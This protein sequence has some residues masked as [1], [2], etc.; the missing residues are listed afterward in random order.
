[1]TKKAKNKNDMGQVIVYKNKVE[2][3][4]ENE[5]V[6]LS[7]NQMADLFERDKSVLSRHLNNVFKEKELAKKSTVANFATVQ[8]EG[9]RQI[10]RRIEY[11]NL[12][13]IISVGYR[14]NSKRGTQFRI[15]ATNVLRK[16]LVEGYTLNK[17]RL[18]KD[19][20]KY[21]ELQ[22]AINLI[23]NVGLI[24]EL[25]TEAK[26][27]ISVISDYARALD[28]LDDYDHQCLKTPKGLKRAKPIFTYEKAKQIILTM[29]EKFKDSPLVGLEKDQ[30]FKSSVNAVYQTFGAKDVYPSVQ[31]K[32]AHLLYFVVK[33][34]SFV[35][36]NK[37]IAAALFIC[38]LD[39]YGILYRKDK[40]KII[41]DMALVGLT[42]MIASS[43]PNEKKMIIKVILNLLV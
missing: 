40:S 28:V 4:L 6:W 17:E 15:W 13:A 21:N 24:A 3:R 29:R 37:R 39:M 5:T 30:S 43:R 18:S 34:H 12:D 22:K 33:N 9:Q 36:G 19:E 26:G 14:V 41:D 35:D 31:E 23:K 8:Q 38:F 7:L 25:S 32:A 27:I 1:M 20:A 2:V 11:Y 42:L 16:H 10:V